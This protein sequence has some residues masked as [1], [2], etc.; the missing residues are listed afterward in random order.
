M[1][2][3][4]YWEQFISTGSINDYLAYKEKETEEPGEKGATPHAGTFKCNRDDITD[5]AYR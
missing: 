2:V 4:N 3:I 1:K 5:G